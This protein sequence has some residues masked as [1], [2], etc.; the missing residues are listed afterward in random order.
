MRL[1]IGPPH[2]SGV[3]LTINTDVREGCRAVRVASPY[4][5]SRTTQRTV[6]IA[7]RH[8]YDRQFDR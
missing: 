7:Q 4:G 5:L 2:L 1:L 6:E 3:A 8:H